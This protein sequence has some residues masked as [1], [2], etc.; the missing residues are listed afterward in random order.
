MSEFKRSASLTILY[1]KP[2]HAI[3]W[4]KINSKEGWGMK[5][6]Y[7]N[8]R[9]NLIMTGSDKMEQED[10]AAHASHSKIKR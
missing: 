10:I 5:K 8:E 7:Q 9:I 3:K 2:L 1:Q 6:S 4:P